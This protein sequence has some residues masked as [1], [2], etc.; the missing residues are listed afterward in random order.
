[1]E[2]FKGGWGPESRA[3]LGVHL[4]TLL[5]VDEEIVNVLTLVACLVGK[6]RS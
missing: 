4:E 1:M 6:K 2:G 5:L 3:Y